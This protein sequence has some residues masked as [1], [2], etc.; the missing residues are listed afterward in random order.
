MRSRPQLAFLLLIMDLIKTGQARYH[1]DMPLPTMTICEPMFQ[2]SD[3]SLMKHFG[4]D[5]I[6]NMSGAYPINTPLPILTQDI[7][8]D[9]PNSSTNVRE[10]DT[11][12]NC[13]CFM[14][15]C[16]KELYANLLQANLNPLYLSKLIIIGNSF[17][18]ITSQSLS[19]LERQKLS[20]IFDCLK[21]CDMTVFPDYHDDPYIFNNTAVHMFDKCNVSC[22]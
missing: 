14:P 6:E 12:G 16:P 22:V 7:E 3:V 17:P 21:F 13:L 15:H 18:S 5:M 2:L 10:E 19:K 20:P 4:F 11:A 1:P 8:N 9:I